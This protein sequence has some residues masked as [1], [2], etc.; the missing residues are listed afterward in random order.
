MVTASA[1]TV[2]AVASVA[3][4][5]AGAGAG[6]TVSAAAAES[7]AAV[8]AASVA[9][10]AAGAAASA[11]AGAV[12][13]SAAAASS[14]AAAALAAAASSTLIKLPLATTFTSALKACFTLELLLL[15]ELAKVR[16]AKPFN[17]EDSCRLTLSPL[18]KCL[19]SDM[20][21]R[22]FCMAS[23]IIFTKISAFPGIGISPP[24]S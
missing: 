9:E 4:R 8:S 21:F 17:A 5:A 10:S 1:F 16:V 12:A 24:N 3:V 7:A 20:T 22:G 23:M 13:A 15:L 11:V 19:S 18:L 6:V 14:E 2:V